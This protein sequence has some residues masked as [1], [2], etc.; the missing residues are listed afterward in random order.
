MYGHPSACEYSYEA[1]P[2]DIPYGPT[3][4]KIGTSERRAFLDGC[5]LG[6]DFVQEV[7][8]GE[9]KQH[10]YAANP[11]AGTMFLYV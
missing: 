7:E 1:A 4:V 9:E 10:G 5:G 6:W 8:S 3:I 11:V 2:Y